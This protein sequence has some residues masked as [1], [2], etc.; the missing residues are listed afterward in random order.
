MKEQPERNLSSE[1][2]VSKL[3][4]LLRVSAMIYQSMGVNGQ[5]S[6]DVR[7]LV[8]LTELLLDLPDS[9]LE[10][11]SGMRESKST[12][13][14]GLADTLHLSEDRSDVAARED[15]HEDTPR[16]NV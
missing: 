16:G 9:L 1:N 8:A 12:R 14:E 11:L 10:L 15:E 13:A 6:L 7:Y 2:S 3:R 4:T 5:A